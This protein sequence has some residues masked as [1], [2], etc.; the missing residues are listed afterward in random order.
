KVEWKRTGRVLDVACDRVEA[1][2]VEFGGFAFF[3]Y[4]LCRLFW[5]QPELGPGVG[6]VG[7]DLEPDAKPRLR[8]PDCRH[9]RTR[10]A[11]D[12]HAASPRISAAALRI[13][14][15]LAR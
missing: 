6:G 10:V 3:P 15:M 9:L 13:A 7:F 11:S 5:T 8:R 1:G 2:S 12:G 4:R 14:A